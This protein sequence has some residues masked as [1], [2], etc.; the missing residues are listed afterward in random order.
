MDT[1]NDNSNPFVSPTELSSPKPLPPTGRRRGRLVPPTVVLLILAALV[2]CIGFIRWRTGQGD[3]A[4]AN[5]LTFLCGFLLFAVS[6]V[7]FAF[8]SGYSRLSRLITCLT[9]GGGLFLAPVVF[10]V[11]HVSGELIPVFRPRWSKRPD[12]LLQRPAPTAQTASA[13]LATTTDF[14]FPQF[15]GPQRSAR[16]DHVELSRDWSSNPPKRIWRQPIGA[17]WSAFAVVDGYAV[18]MEQRG[19]EEFV[20]CY[21]VSSGKLAWSHATPTRHQTVPGG[22]GPRSTPTIHR[23][24]V[25]ALG[26]TGE[27]LCLDGRN[28]SVIWRDNL[29]Q[30]Y[31]VPVEDDAK[32]VAWGRAGSPLVVDNLIVVPAGGP[33]GGPC[34][35]LAAFNQET[36]SLVWESGRDQISYSSPILT[37]LAGVR[38]IISVNESTVTGHEPSTGKQL[39]DIS[40]PGNSTAETNVSQ[41]VPVGE[42]QLLLSK[43]YGRGAKLLRMTHTT[44]GAFSFQDVWHDQKLLKTKFTNVVVYQKHVYGLSDG[45]MECVD[46]DNGEQRWKRGRFG[47]GQI[48]GVGGVILVQAESGEVVMIAATP[49]GF[50]ELGRFNALDGITWN[51]L[52]LTGKRLLVRNAQEAT[53]YELP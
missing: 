36:G 21:E 11:D 33:A 6:G 24:R 39:W 29:L 31:H 50:D 2:A 52:C 8:F 4:T 40:W 51:N 5:L 42:D 43:G 17:G 37:T 32:G 25:Y 47:Q 35:S 30:R 18:T 53:C 13:D 26:A 9:I 10:R 48:L 23:G 7:W 16:V 3:F 45:I 12:E 20:T 41:P 15:L 38:Q 34:I 44:N 46:L 28:G 49:D 1:Q 14:D 19:L 27:L 22:I